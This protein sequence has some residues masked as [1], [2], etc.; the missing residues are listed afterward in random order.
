MK[1]IARGILFFVDLLY[2]AIAAKLNQ[3]HPHRCQM[4]QMGKEKM[5]VP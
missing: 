5:M 3:N 2:E 1:A 4:I